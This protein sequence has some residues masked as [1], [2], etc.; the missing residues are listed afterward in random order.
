MFCEIAS[1]LHSSQWHVPFVIA[2]RLHDSID[3]NDFFAGQA[4]A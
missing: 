1:L 2:E 4:S 3:G